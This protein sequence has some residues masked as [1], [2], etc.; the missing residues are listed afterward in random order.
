MRCS[1]VTHL[2]I[3][4]KRREAQC[5][6][7]TALQS[8]PL[9]SLPAIFTAVCDTVRDIVWP[10]WRSRWTQCV[11]QKKICSPHFQ[12]STLMNHNQIIHK[13]PPQFQTNRMAQKHVWLRV[14]VYLVKKQQVDE[15][16]QLVFGQP[17]TGNCI[18]K[19]CLRCCQPLYQ[20]IVMSFCFPCL[21]LCLIRVSGEIC[22]QKLSTPETHLNNRQRQT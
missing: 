14:R 21:W 19:I 11:V 22:G 13:L 2:Q 16:A 18:T 4:H 20:A 6:V 5:F 17:A 9:N 10:I 8:L 3:W 1:S 12:F 15:L 7:K